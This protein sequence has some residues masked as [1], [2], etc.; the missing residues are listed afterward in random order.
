MVETKLGD[1][2]EITW[3]DAQQD[4]DWQDYIDLDI[5]ELCEF[6]TTGYFLK[7]GTN[8]IALCQSFDNQILQDGRGLIDSI[9]QVP[10]ATIRNIRKLD[11]LD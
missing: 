11:T 3:I 9:M 7:E 10:K 2:L 8:Y 1:K 6:V 5:N 4:S